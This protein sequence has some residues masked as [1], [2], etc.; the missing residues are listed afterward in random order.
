MMT[1]QPGKK[2]TACKY[3]DFFFKIHSHFVSSTDWNKRQL[4]LQNVM[5]GCGVFAHIS[6]DTFVFLYTQLMTCVAPNRNIITNMPVMHEPLQHS[7]H[8]IP[9]Y[10]WFSSTDGVTQACELEIRQA[11]LHKQPGGCWGSAQVANGIL[12]QDLFDH[13]SRKHCYDILTHHTNILIIAS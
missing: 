2:N 1:K 4:F 12:G 13:M 11:L 3:Q 6:D 8:S 10:H 7:Q 5:C 9:T